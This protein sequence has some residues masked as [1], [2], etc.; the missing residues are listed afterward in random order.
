[1]QESV[2]FGSSALREVETGS[3]KPGEPITGAAQ[4]YLPA[5]VSRGV[6]NQSQ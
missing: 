4:T 1:M 3:L 2:L 5:G 6:K